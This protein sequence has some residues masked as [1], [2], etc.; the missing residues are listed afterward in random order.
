MTKNPN[1]NASKHK[2]GTWHHLRFIVDLILQ[3]KAQKSAIQHLSIITP[4]SSLQLPL[5]ALDAQNNS[6][7]SNFLR[8]ECSI[9]EPSLTSGASKALVVPFT[10]HCLNVLANDWS[11]ALLALGGLS[12]CTLCLTVQTP[13]ITILLDMC[14]SF[15]E[16]ITTL[17]TKEVSIVPVLSQR[18]C[19]LSDDRSLTVFA[20][21]GVVFMPIEMTEIAKS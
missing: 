8:I 13:S 12:F 17:S 2:R 18:D 10:A 3:G 6:L 20:F 19:M 4:P 1:E 7:I 11:L 16:R 14:H 21:G 15:L 9:I 5:N